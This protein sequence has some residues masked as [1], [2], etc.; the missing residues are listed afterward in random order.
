MVHVIAIDVGIINLAIVELQGDRECGQ[1]QILNFALVDITILRHRSV[2]RSACTLCHGRSL[3]DRV[4]HFVQEYAEAFSRAHTVL[5]EQQPPGGHQAVE[6]LLYERF[7]NKAQLVSPVAMQAY[8]K[9]RGMTYEERKVVSETLASTL[10]TS[11]QCDSLGGLVRQHDVCDA[12]CMALFWWRN[13]FR[14]SCPVPSRFT[15]DAYA[16]IGQFAFRRGG[17]ADAARLAACSVHLDLAD[18]QDGEIVARAQHPDSIPHL[19]AKGCLLQRREGG[20]GGEDGLDVS[21]EKRDPHGERVLAEHVKDIL[22]HEESSRESPRANC[23]EAL[24]E[25]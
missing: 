15:A 12:I 3:A 11:T 24:P 25:K 13:H 17:D 21:T 9:M 4:A 14:P 10:L 18:V 22:V 1:L 19:A 2:R 8:F 16:F 7:R 5:I 23:C 20:D 6:Q